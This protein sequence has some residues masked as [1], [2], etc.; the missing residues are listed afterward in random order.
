MAKVIHAVIFIA[1][2]L[3]AT[4]PLGFMPDFESRSGTALV[5]CSGYG[6][7]TVYVDDD[8][9]QGHHAAKPCAYSILAL[10]S[11]PAAPPELDL[12]AVVVSIALPNS[13][14]PEFLQPRYLRPHAIG[15]PLFV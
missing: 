10:F 3:Q 4:I 11:G 14:S 12:S 2:L 5:I 9:Q 7:K 6:E 8:G 13:T 1:F 15:P